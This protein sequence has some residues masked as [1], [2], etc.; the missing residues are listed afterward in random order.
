MHIKRT[1]CP[2]LPRW[3]HFLAYWAV[4]PHWSVLSK[5]RVGLHQCP[6]GHLHIRSFLNPLSICFCMC[7]LHVWTIHKCIPPYMHTRF[8]LTVHLI[9]LRRGLLV[10]LTTSAFWLAW[11]V[12]QQVLR[13]YLSVSAV[14]TG[15]HS[16]RVR[17][18]TQVFMLR[19][20]ASFPTESS[21]P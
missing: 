2:S 3:G 17:T 5:L 16:I 20:Q 8:S 21:L 12:G 4:V 6:H 10:N 7:G 14:V 1:K 11:L 13:I 9:T 18:W 19:E 15:S